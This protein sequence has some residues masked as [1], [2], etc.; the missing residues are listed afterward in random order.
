MSEGMRKAEA[1][2]GAGSTQ[3]PKAPG[4]PRLAVRLRNYFFAGILVTAPVTITFWLAWKVIRF[5]DEQVAVFIPPKWNPESYL[6]FGLPGIGMIVAFIVLT[7][8][9]FLAAGYAGR[10]VTG[11]GERMLAG[12][13]VVRSIYS[14]TKQVFETVLSQKGTAFKDV[15]LIEYPCRGI[16]AIGFI[17]GKTEGEVQNLTAETVYNVFIPATPNPTTG[18]L[19]FIPE[20]DVHH[21]DMTVEEGIKLVISGGIVEPPKRGAGEA[22]AD[23]AAQPERTDETA[24]EEE[25]GHTRFD[26]VKRVRNYFFAGV[27]VTA[28]VSITIWLTWELISFIDDRV[29]P[30]IPGR[31]NPETYLPFSLPGLGV[32]L[33]VVVLIVIGFLTAGIV[34]RTLVGF[35]EQVLHRMPVIRNVYGAIKQL[36]ETVF[37]EQSQA[38]RQCVLIQYPRAESWAIGFLTGQTESHIQDLTP[39]TA[40]NVFLPTTPNPTSGFLLFVPRR[41]VDILGMTVEEGIKMVV[42]GGIVTPPAPEGEAAPT[43]GKTSEVA[44][45]V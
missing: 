42:S 45:T 15:V 39:D 34:G 32:V 5:V 44:E 43:P 31:W 6:P 37:R 7:L 14:W 21:V 11:L 29:V 26:L 33:A 24:Q 28:P 1:K 12:V 3:K 8:I 36:I 16:W 17:T 30:V 27:L 38:F 41:D 19:L 40:V 18:F 4:R 20:R 22:E 35:G 2:A 25:T 13:P 23:L 9:G 10:A